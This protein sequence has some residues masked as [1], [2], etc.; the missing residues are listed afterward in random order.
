V[1]FHANLK[2]LKDSRKMVNR[3]SLVW[4]CQCCHLALKS[5]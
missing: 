5:E 1:S 2:N 3:N 4:N